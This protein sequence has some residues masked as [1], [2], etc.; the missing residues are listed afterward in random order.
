M[1]ERGQRVIL[2]II[3]FLVRYPLRLIVLPLLFVC[4]GDLEDGCVPSHF[5]MLPKSLYCKTILHRAFVD[6]VVIPSV[7]ELLLVA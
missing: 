2:F 7:T 5:R 1:I 4:E 3:K 6:S